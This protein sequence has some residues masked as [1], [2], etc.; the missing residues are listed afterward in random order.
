MGY[1][2]QTTSEE[3]SLSFL[4]PLKEV[5]EAGKNSPTL[6]ISGSV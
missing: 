3:E 4:N 5:F 6:H 1:M 2:K